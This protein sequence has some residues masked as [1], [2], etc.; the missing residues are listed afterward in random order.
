MK[1][2]L[3]LGIKCVKNSVVVKIINDLGLTIISVVHYSTEILRLEKSAE[4]YKYH[5]MR[6][7]RYSVTSSKMINRVLDFYRVDD[8]E[9]TKRRFY[10]ND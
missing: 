5:I 8:P 2:E 6:L 7:D 10:V 3:E 4:S 9:I 1:I